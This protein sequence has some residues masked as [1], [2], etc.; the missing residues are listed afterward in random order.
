MIVLRRLIFAGMGLWMLG[1]TQLFAQVQ[2]GEASYYADKYHLSSPT[3]SGEL[4]D[5]YKFTAAHRTLDFG[6]I[7]KVTNLTNN[8]TVTVRVND[9]G[10]YKK[11]RIIDLSRAAA[12]QVDLIQAGLA[13]VKIEVVV[14]GKKQSVGTSRSSAAARKSETTKPVASKTKTLKVTTESGRDVSKLPLRDHTGAL[15]SESAT[16]TNP[17]ERISSTS[18]STSTEVVQGVRTISVQS[19]TDI[20]ERV[21]RVMPE[22]REITALDIK[23]GMGQATVS[24]NA[25]IATPATSHTSNKR[26]ASAGIPIGTAPNSTNIVGLGEV[27]KYTPNV[28]RMIAIKDNSAGFAV[29]LGAFYNYYRLME[30]LSNINGKGVDNTLVH[31]GVKD[32][33]PIFRILAGPY[34]SK[35]AA[36]QAKTSLRRKGLNGLT[37]NI[38]SLN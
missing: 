2:Y 34:T 12:E 19:N 17:T 11:G 33:K 13:K 37:V 30:G 35:A 3:A 21:R 6:T 24:N 4:Y 18:P 28:Y 29:Q 27:S 5:K 36:D 7:L 26:L 1:M 20:D 25:T 16:S 38:K 8:R 14:Q 32:G 15:I 23:E 9:R 10:P 22:Y 31:N